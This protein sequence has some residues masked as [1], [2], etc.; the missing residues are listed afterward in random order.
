MPNLLYSFVGG[1]CGALSRKLPTFAAELAYPLANIINSSIK[2]GVLPQTWKGEIV[3]P[4]ANVYPPKLLKNLRS[5]SGL[6]SFKQVQEKLISEIIILDMKQKM[7][8][9]QYGNQSGL[10]IQCYHLNM[11]NKILKDT[12]QGVTAVLATFV[13][14]KDAILNQCPKLGIEAF[15]KCLKC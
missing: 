13:D 7:D 15:L 14:W 4:V 11:I 10:C 5:I 3:T 12:D 9:S 2:Q 8:P 6:T 1:S